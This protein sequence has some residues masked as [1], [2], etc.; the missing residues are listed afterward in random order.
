[1]LKAQGIAMV[2]ASALQLHP[3][4][5]VVAD[6]AAASEL[7]LIDYYKQVYEGKPR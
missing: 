1:M 6:E 2:P 7:K 3:H 4:V 5:T